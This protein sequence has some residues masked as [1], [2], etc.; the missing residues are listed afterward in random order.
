VKKVIVAMSGGVDSS[1]AAALL[2]HDGYDVEGIFM[3]NWSPDTLQAL[4]DCPWEQDQADAAAVCAHLGIPF[5]SINFEREYK[6]LVVDYFLREYAAGRTPNPDVMCNKEIKFSVFLR[7]ALKTGADFVATGH[8]AR[9]EGETQRRLLRGVDVRKDQSY[10]LYA[11]NAEQ[12]ANVMLPIGGLKKDS[13]RELAREF[14][15]P[16]AEKKDSQGICFIG[17]IDLKEFLREQLGTKVGQVYML[18]EYDGTRTL[19]ERMQRSLLVG[20]H[21]GSMFY[22]LGERAKSCIDNRLY[23]IVVGETD[24]KPCYVVAR[25]AGNNAL[26]VS[27]DHEDPHLYS[28]KITIER[29]NGTGS[30]ENS[31]ILS[32]IDISGISAQVRY[33][34]PAKALYGFVKHDDGTVTFESEAHWAVAPGQSLVL[35]RGDEVIGGGIICATS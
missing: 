2:Q 35:Y 5:R 22:T 8:Y 4:T 1:V 14:G 28:S 32:T 31:D 25:E 21:Q 30:A 10:F 33:Q 26:Y 27:R 9:V 7:E 20:K 3:K 18:P 16:T 17:H 34:E 19:A 15:L 24:V 12:V 11:L 23:R 29:F 13:V 6:E